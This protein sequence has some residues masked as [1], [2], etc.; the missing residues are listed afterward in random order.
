MAAGYSSAGVIIAGV[1]ARIIFVIKRV[2]FPSSPEYHGKCIYNQMVCPLG[3]F[4]ILW[5]EKLYILPKTTIACAIP[6][7]KYVA[8]TA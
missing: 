4:P 3:E 2:F 1:V 8:R 5:D 7:L 6:L